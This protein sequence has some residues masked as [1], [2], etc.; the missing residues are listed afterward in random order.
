MGF[1][2][3]TGTGEDDVQTICLQQGHIRNHIRNHI[4]SITSIFGTG[5]TNRVHRDN[6]DC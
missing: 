6:G 3:T 1:T 2:E 4:T 5:N